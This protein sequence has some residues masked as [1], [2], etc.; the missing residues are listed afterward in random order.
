MIITGVQEQPWEGYSTTKERV[1]ETI[2]AAMGGNQLEESMKEARKNKHIMLQSYWQ[3]PVK[4]PST[5]KCHI[6]LQRRSTKSSGKQKKSSQWDLH[7]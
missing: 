4:P 5:N 6:Q 3:V 2:A 1:L 7:Q